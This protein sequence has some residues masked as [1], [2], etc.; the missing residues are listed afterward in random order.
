M[1][2]TGVT[3]NF[4]FEARTGLKKSI[5]FLSTRGARSASAPE[6]TRMVR[7]AID[8]A[9]AH[10]GLAAFAEKREPIFRGE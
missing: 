2:L 4:I 3:G 8:S 5:L 10:E 6:I 1:G 9:D 7:E